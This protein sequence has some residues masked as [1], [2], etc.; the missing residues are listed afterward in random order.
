MSAGLSVT[1]ARPVHATRCGTQP[2]GTVAGSV[3][4]AT[5][6][7]QCRWGGKR[8]EAVARA[9]ARRRVPGGTRGRGVR[10]SGCDGAGGRHAGRAGVGPRARVAGE[11]AGRACARARGFGGGELHVLVG[12]GRAGG[13][14]EQR[15]VRRGVGGGEGARHAQQSLWRPAPAQL[16]GGD[17]R[18]SPP[19]RP[20]AQ[21]GDS[22][23]ACPP[24]AVP[25]PTLAMCGRDSR[26]CPTAAARAAAWARWGGSCRPCPSH[27]TAAWT[28]QG[29]P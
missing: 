23:A 19:P 13:R 14:K 25:P 18:P 7:S 8:M 9:R 5:P 26:W 20:W 2:I 12:V 1:L 27:S 21:V 6:A 16:T 3:V 17:G 10:W 4:S 29:Q 15:R 28:R 11:H 24:L 22:L